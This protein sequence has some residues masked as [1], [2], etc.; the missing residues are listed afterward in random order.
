MRKGLITFYSSK[1]KPRIDHGS[2]GVKNTIK[3][4]CSRKIKPA[5][6]ASDPKQETN[7]WQDF[8]IIE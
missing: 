2:K 7:N 6:T 5:K 1:Y 3:Q 8:A 4:L